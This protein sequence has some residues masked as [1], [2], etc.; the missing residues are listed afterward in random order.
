M[1]LCLRIECHTSQLGPR[2]R[3]ST[4]HPAVTPMLRALSTTA[5]G[6][7]LRCRPKRFRTRRHLVLAHFLAAIVDGHHGMLFLSLWLCSYGSSRRGARLMGCVT[8]GPVAGGPAAL[9]LL[10]IGSLQHATPLL[11]IARRD[12]HQS[13]C[14]SRAESRPSSFP[15]ILPKAPACPASRRCLALQSALRSAGDSW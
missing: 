6:R 9:M 8:A 1:C 15:L 14:A 2:S 13:Y 7:R 5:C 4:I 12:C 3:R 10:T 11:R